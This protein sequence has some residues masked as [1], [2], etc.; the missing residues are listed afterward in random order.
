MEQQLTALAQRDAIIGLCATVP[1]VGLIV[2]C[3]FVAVIDE[4]RRFH[5]AHAVGAY[6]GLVP[7][8]ATTGGPGK[9]RLGSITKQGNTMARVMLVQAAWL[10]LRSRDTTDP[11]RRWA[12]NLVE[13]RGKRIAVVAL[14][15]KLAGVLWAMWRDGTVYDRATNAAASAVG[16]RRDARKQA[17]RA[18]ALRT[19]ATKFNRR[20]VAA[21][22]KIS[23]ATGM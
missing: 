21:A 9:R 1:G 5:N 18:D 16:V 8:E 19:S 4:A 7:G 13:K 14:A 6:L 2:A 10:I 17:H 23:E 11:L 3:T 22:N 15:R 12:D 20:A